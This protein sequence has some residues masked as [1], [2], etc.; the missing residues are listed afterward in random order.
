MG[1][2]E[3]FYVYAVTPKGGVFKFVL[4]AVSPEHARKSAEAEG[5]K[6]SK[7]RRIPTP[8]KGGRIGQSRNAP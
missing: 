5:Y 3:A 6:V 8:G 7:V 1:G 2:T 4:Y